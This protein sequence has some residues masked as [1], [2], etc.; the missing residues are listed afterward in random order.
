MFAG[1]GASMKVLFRV[2]TLAMVMLILGLPAMRKVGA[3]SPAP[4][5][6]NS[7][8]AP[9]PS[10]TQ[11]PASQRPPQTT[12]SQAYPAAQVEGGQSV[13]LQQCAFCHGRDAGGGE[14]GP[15]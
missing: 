8:S 14:T 13:F 7:P 1:R 2:G 5:S 9:T 4:Q 3:K 6:K 10:P 15:D 12:T 11:S